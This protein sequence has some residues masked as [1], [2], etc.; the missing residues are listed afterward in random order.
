[1]KLKSAFSLAIHPASSVVVCKVPCIRLSISSTGDFLAVGDADGRVYL[2]R[3]A[4]LAQQATFAC[5]DFVVTGVSFAPV[6]TSEQ[7]GLKALIVSCSA[8]NKF[9]AMKYTGGMSTTLKYALL[10]MFLVVMIVLT[11]KTHLILEYL[12]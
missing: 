2:Y 4:S 5:H 8:D 10:F 11:N 9:V 7:F 12:P 1:M 3:S 6:S